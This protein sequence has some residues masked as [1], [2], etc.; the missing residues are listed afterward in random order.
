[1]ALAVDLMGVGLPQEQA[2]RLG[3]SDL[4]TIAGATTAQATATLIPAQTNNVLATTAVGQ[5]GF[6]LPA[7]AELEVPYLV[8]NSTATAALVFPPTGGTINAAAANASVSIAQNLARMFVRKS[9]TR[10]VSFLT[11]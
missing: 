8:T 5:T 4:T 10:W 2:V 9:A 7:D 3:F 6:R 11:A 1:M